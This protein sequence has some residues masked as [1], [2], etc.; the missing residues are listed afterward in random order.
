[1]SIYIGDASIF[2]RLH[3]L[4]EKNEETLGVLWQRVRTGGIGIGKGEEDL[5]YSLGRAST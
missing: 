2:V 3:I 1:M 5:A 4:P